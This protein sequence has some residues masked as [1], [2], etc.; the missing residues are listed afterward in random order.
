MGLKTE[1]AG[2]ADAKA[3]V[4]QVDEWI[5]Q[6]DTIG[7]GDLDAFLSTVGN[8]LATANENPF[9]GVAPQEKADFIT[10]LQALI[11]NAQ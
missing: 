6:I 11:T 4:E 8:I 3:T 1:L 9:L 2:L 7:T 5:T 10:R